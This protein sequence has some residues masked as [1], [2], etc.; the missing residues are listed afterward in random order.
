MSQ[1]TIPTRQQSIPPITVVV[2]WDN[3]MRT[4]FALVCQE[5]PDDR[6]DDD[7]KTLV[8]VG[9]DYDEIKTLEPIIEAVA[10]WADISQETQQKLLA[11]QKEGATYQ[12]SAIQSWVEELAQAAKQINV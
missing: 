11:D 10:P 12:P 3:P 2:G 9:T 5:P 6:P 7:P 4:F 8:W 1:H